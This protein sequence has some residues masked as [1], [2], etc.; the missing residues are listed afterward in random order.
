MPLKAATCLFSFGFGLIQ[1][2]VT[3][4]ITQFCAVGICIT[5]QYMKI[6]R[7]LTVVQ[8]QSSKA[9]AV[10]KLSGLMSWSSFW[11]SFWDQ[12][13]WINRWSSVFS[14]QIS[15]GLKEA[16]SMW[17]VKIMQ[18]WEDFV[19]RIF[20]KAEWVPRFNNHPFETSLAAKNTGCLGWP[21][22]MYAPSKCRKSKNNSPKNSHG[23]WTWRFAKKGALFSG[24]TTIFARV[25]FLFTMKSI[26]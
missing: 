16:A 2:S 17:P 10:R 11:S 23:N 24:S 14:N 3:E 8:Y 20:P 7:Y 18:K 5:P 15:L 6:H 13:P 22:G 1:L 21:R 4:D 19:G 26:R 12:K 25:S 9:T